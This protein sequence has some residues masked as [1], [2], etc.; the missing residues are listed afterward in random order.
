MSVSEIKRD[1]LWQFIRKKR[2]FTI[3][4]LHNNT[5]P[6][7]HVTSIETYIHQ[8]LK[9]G[10]IE[11]IAEHKKLTRNKYRYYVEFEYRL[12]KD[13]GAHRPVLDSNGQPK[14]PSG[15][16]RIWSAIKVLKTFDYRDVTLTTAA[17]PNTVKKYLIT[18]NR[19][20]YLRIVVKG[21]SHHADRFL[22]MRKMDTGPFAPRIRKNGA[23]YDPN[24]KKDVWQKGQ[25]A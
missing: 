22:F 9:G 15:N 12:V 2:T 4:D 1:A 14:E 23:V 21:T 8:L 25:A 10:Y 17:A 13:T 24:L 16:Q 5:T 18:L 6:V 11:K 19:A 20:G 3:S 7:M